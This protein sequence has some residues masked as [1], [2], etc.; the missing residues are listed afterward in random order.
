MEPVVSPLD[1]P[2]ASFPHFMPNQVLTHTQLNELAVYLEQQNRFT[3]QRLIGIG[4]VCGLQVNR[5]S[6]GNNAVVNISRGVGITSC[7]FLI[8]VPTTLSFGRKKPYTT[9]TDYD[10]FL[11]GAGNG[12]LD[13]FELKDAATTESGTSLLYPAD[14]IGK[15]VVL[16][17]D[18][19]DKPNGKCIGENCDEKGNKWVFNLRALLIPIADMNKIIKRTYVPNTLGN[20]LGTDAER[21]DYFHPAYQLPTVFVERF[22]NLN[23]DPNAPFNLSAI[24]TFEDLENYYRTAILNSS[25]RVAQALYETYE[26]FKPVF[27]NQLGTTSNPFN[28]FQNPQASNGLATMLGKLIDPFNPSYKR[29]SCQYVYDF[30]RDLA[31]TYHELRDELFQLASRCSPDPTRFPRH[32]MLGEAELNLR[33][34]EFVPEAYQPP[35]VYRHFFI[36]SPIHNEQSQHLK[37]VKMLIRRIELMINTLNFDGIITGDD[38]EPILITPDKS[39]CSPLGEQRIPFYYHVEGAW[40]LTGYW[41]YDYTI[42]NR[43]YENRSYWASKYVDT[44]LPPAL[45]AALVTPLLADICSLPKLSIE[46]HVG[47][48]LEDAVNELKRLRRH[49]NLSFDL[50]AL[51]LSRQL[52]EVAIADDALIADLQAQYLIERNELVCCLE[53]LLEYTKKHEKL[54]GALLLLI[55]SLL[56]E[57]STVVNSG[58]INWQDL[59]SDLLDGYQVSISKMIEA[60]PEDI[61][62]FNFPLLNAIFPA[63]NAFTT[64]FKYGVNT[65]GDIES[66]LLTD[67]ANTTFGSIAGKWMLSDLASAIL[68]FW[69][70]FLD[71][72]GDDCILG[73]F[74]TIA[75][76]FKT[77]LQTFTLFSSFNESIHGMEHIAGTTKGGT[78]ILVYE[79]EEERKDVIG[80]VFDESGKAVEGAIIV[81]ASNNNVMYGVTDSKG[82]FTI[83]VPK[84]VKSV[85]IVKPGHAITE[86]KATATGKASRVSMPTYCAVAE[87]KKAKAPTA[88]SEVDRVYV[89]LKSSFDQMKAADKALF[90]QVESFIKFDAATTTHMPYDIGFKR[91]FRVVADFYL[92][93]LIHNCK[94]DVDP[95]DACKD[96]E[97]VKLVDFSVITKLL[98]KYV[99]TKAE[100]KTVLNAFK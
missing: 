78:F 56:F 88:M 1:Q 30:V 29:G 24:T 46:G 62:K 11:V 43:T 13:C 55:L 57:N 31:D 98:D 41:N 61:R 8:D 34:G 40:K 33:F 37:K 71:K 67:R 17:L 96:L 26:V 4:I 15:I 72:V 22:G 18:L 20:P 16:F 19:Q 73:K 70:L 47:K 76:M 93:H 6:A 75:T 39:C 36:S 42:Q 86:M 48:I 91:S 49:Y 53:D 7:G 14:V 50:L 97:E 85:R 5:V 60:L 45:R 90:G 35:T 77:R 54:I 82:R 89:N 64:L 25:T 59:I 74:Y 100:F 66:F 12:P 32:L 80:N 58:Q 83:R 52:D 23:N 21:E 68:N 79:D 51:K 94:I 92:P 69:E 99:K 95:L 38:K 44:N 2:L 3:R 9:P 28:G 84:D 10:P 81:N 27:D 65:W 87:G 63:F